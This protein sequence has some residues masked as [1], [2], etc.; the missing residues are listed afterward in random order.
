[1][2]RAD[3][4]S[5]VRGPKNS[6]SLRG[7]NQTDLQLDVIFGFM[8]SENTTRCDSVPDLK[9][10]RL[11]RPLVSKLNRL[12]GKALSQ[13][14][15]TRFD[16]T[17]FLS[18]N[19]RSPTI[20]LDAH[21]SPLKTFHAIAG[22][23]SKSD[24]SLGNV[25]LITSNA[26]LQSLSPFMNEELID[27][28]GELFSI[29][30]SIIVTL[31]SYQERRDF[32]SLQSIAARSHGS[33]M[34]LVTKSSYYTL[35]R[36]ALFENG[37]ESLD[38]F[39]RDYFDDLDAW[40]AST[41]IL[42]PIT[43]SYRNEMII[44]YMIRLIAMNASTLLFPFIPILL[45]W[46][47]EEYDMTHDFHYLSIK[48]SLMAEFWLSHMK[49]ESEKESI[50]VFWAF[51]ISDHYRD[52]FRQLSPQSS[53]SSVENRYNEVMIGIFSK[54]NYIQFPIMKQISTLSGEKRN[55]L[56]QLVYRSILL[57]HSNPNVNRLL[58]VILSQ[59]MEEALAGASLSSVETDDMHALIVEFLQIWL[60]FMR[61]RP[62]TYN[63]LYPGNENMFRGCAT[64]VKY[65]VRLG[66]Q[67]SR[68]CL[69]PSTTML[70][71][72]LQ[73]EIL[74]EAIY[75]F[76][77]YFLDLDYLPSISIR[78]LEALVR[79]ILLIQGHALVLTDFNANQE[80]RSF[81]SWLTANENPIAQH[82]AV[83]LL[84]ALYI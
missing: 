45:Q 38:D 19:H 52:L 67:R 23:S 20:D 62:L 79:E 66:R 10:R 48:C 78:E 12:Q 72:L 22:F 73:F 29:L 37:Q 75:L 7:Y 82:I 76:Q 4:R 65:L 41:E 1:M 5:S 54:S 50:K 34:A 17:S 81:I 40:L 55:H 31:I 30:R 64:L 68:K 61:D 11:L 53:A 32:L 36:K 71:K 60:S 15:F 70:R 6:R 44:G 58:A 26:R 9:Y 27:E 13:A 25:S 69:S 56:L 18:Q 33:S 47:R 28:Y 16:Y 83:I 84:H 42:S 21:M 80:L 77:A 49:H 43:H 57:D 35:N 74:V 63:S 24:L 59:I 51:Y 14:D 8:S 39:G 3:L 2:S 46:L